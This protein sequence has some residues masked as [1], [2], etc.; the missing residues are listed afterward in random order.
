MK[1]IISLTFFT[2][3]RE[4]Y[5]L[6]GTDTIQILKPNTLNLFNNAPSNTKKLLIKKIEESLDNNKSIKLIINNQKIIIEP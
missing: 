4:L 2:F 3:F 5:S 6:I 1:N